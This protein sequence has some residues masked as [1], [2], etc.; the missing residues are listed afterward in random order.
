VE[1]SNAL[2]TAG[3][4]ATKKNKKKEKMNKPM[5][6]SGVL[7]AVV[8]LLAFVEQAGAYCVHNN[9]DRS[10]TVDQTSNASS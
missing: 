10:V 1:T 8:S 7:M 9:T 4:H 5:K 6:W 3:K 2:H